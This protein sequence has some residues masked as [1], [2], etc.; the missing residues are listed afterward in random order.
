MKVWIRY[1]K[2]QPDIVCA[3]TEEDAVAM[4]CSDASYTTEVAEVE[5]IDGDWLALSRHSSYRDY[6]P[7]GDEYDRTLQ[8]IFDGFD[9]SADDS[10]ATHSGE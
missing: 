6:T 8:E 1:F 5:E 10:T 2:T 9:P 4:D 7:V 3:E